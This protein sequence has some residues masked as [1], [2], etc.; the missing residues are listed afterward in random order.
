MPKFEFNFQEFSKQTYNQERKIHMPV[1]PL[2]ELK[3]AESFEPT[4]GVS[5]KVVVQIYGYKARYEWF[6]PWTAFECLHV[7]QKSFTICSLSMVQLAIA[8]ALGFSRACLSYCLPSES[9][10]QESFYWTSQAQR[11]S[12]I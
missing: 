2:A 12:R 4:L 1:W 11:Q 10:S 9:K 6:F 3:A 5:M 7:A 8:F